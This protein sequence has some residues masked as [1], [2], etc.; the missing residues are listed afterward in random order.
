MQY[1]SNNTIK[2][3]TLTDAYSFQIAKPPG[4]HG[5]AKNVLLC[6]QRTTI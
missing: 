4:E 3:D 6:T 1:V 2:I 5:G